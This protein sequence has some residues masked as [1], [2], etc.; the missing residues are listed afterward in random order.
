MNNS[1]KASYKN[2]VIIWGAMAFSIV[3]Y[4]VVVELLKLG[5]VDPA[6]KEQM[7]L[8]KMVFWTIAASYV[9]IIPFLKKVMLKPEGEQMTPSSTYS[10]EKLQ[11]YSLIT[12]AIAESVCIYGLVFYI[13]FHSKTDFYILAAV[14]CAYF[15]WLFPKKSEW[16]E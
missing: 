6:E 2:T 11:T 14:S 10:P 9:F 16:P 1:K 12:F 13:L 4:I 8:L 7:N 3:L 15:F 5:E